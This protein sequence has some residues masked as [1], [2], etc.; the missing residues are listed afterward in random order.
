MQNNFFYMFFVR[1]PG[2]KRIDQNS[3]LQKVYT[4]VVLVVQLCGPHMGTHMHIHDMFF[5]CSLHVL[6]RVVFV[7]FFSFSGVVIRFL[8]HVFFVASS[9]SLVH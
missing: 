8:L 2:V 5:A 7:Q 1:Y 9:R 6:C 4:T 3:Y